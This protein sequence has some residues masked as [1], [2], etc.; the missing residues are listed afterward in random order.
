MTT[1]GCNGPKTMHIFQN[2][3]VTSKLMVHKK[4]YTF[5]DPAFQGLPCGVLLFAVSVSFKNHKIA[6]P[7]WLLKNCCHSEGGF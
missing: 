4:M 5:S 6:A 3:Q 1:A 2:G 7:Y